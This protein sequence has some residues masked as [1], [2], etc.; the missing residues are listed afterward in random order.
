ML[1]IMC[2]YIMI[3]YITT[4]HYGY[5][6]IPLKK[7]ISVVPTNVHTLHKRCIT[8]SVRVY[9]TPYTAVLHRV[10]NTFIGVHASQEGT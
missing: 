6:A 10:C 4:T 3:L 9:S 5:T 1:Y 7:G 8:L 2:A